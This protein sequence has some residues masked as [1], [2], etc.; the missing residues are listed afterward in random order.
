MQG[1]ESTSVGWLG[2]D[3]LSGKVGDEVETPG[4]EHVFHF[5][6]SRAL[7]DDWVGGMVWLEGGEEELAAAEL[8]AISNG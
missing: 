5:S 2:D 1:C 4:L 6:W 8:E 7:C 3:V